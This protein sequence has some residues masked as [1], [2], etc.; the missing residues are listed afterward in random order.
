[1]RDE[2]IG[3]LERILGLRDRYRLDVSGDAE[4]RIDRRV[5]L[6]LAVGMDV[7][8]PASGL[9]L[10]SVSEQRPRQV[11]DRLA[12]LAEG[13][14]VFAAEP[15]EGLELVSVC[16]VATARA[17]LSPGRSLP[18]RANLLTSPCRSLR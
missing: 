15:Q 16:S 4:R 18:A 13:Q 9:A 3:G 8:R 17:S 6:A 11:G 7:L 14:P 12:R 10:G 5:V 2:R 1:V